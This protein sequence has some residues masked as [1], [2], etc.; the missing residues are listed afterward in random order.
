MSACHA[1]VAWNA[2]GARHRSIRY[3]LTIRRLVRDHGIKNHASR[4]HGCV[5]L[6]YQNFILPILTYT[7]G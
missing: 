1:N 3:R 2:S 6:A 4:I 5:V 7:V